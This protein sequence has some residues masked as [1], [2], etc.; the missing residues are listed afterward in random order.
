MTSWTPTADA[1]LRAHWRAGMLTSTIA[2]MLYTTKNSVIGRAHRLGLPARK[3]PIAGRISRPRV[4]RAPRFYAPRVA[5]ERVPFEE[6]APQPPPRREPEPI[7]AAAAPSAQNPEAESQ[8][9]RPFILPPG[10]CQWIAGQPSA[11]DACKCGQRS[12]PGRPYCPDHEAKAYQ[13]RAPEPVE[14]A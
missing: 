5:A 4:E 7:E 8:P 6:P 11:D 2:V 12:V 9:Y 10:R 3:N 1:K 13:R 14:A